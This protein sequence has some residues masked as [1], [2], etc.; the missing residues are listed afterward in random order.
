MN[1]PYTTL[2]GMPKDT[3]RPLI[4]A[5]FIHK[6]KRTL[7]ILCLVDSGADYSYVTIEVASLLEID[8]QKITADRKS[9]V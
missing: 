3:K 8:L 2:P 9:V 7:P 4:P 1:F 6:N 5:R